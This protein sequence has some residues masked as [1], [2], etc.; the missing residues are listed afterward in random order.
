[1]VVLSSQRFRGIL[2]LWNGDVGPGRSPDEIGDDRAK[3]PD[4]DKR[5]RRD[6][7]FDGVLRCLPAFSILNLEGDGPSGRI[8]RICFGERISCR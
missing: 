5:D 3:I 8:A 1:M 4:R 6:P 7:C 2:R